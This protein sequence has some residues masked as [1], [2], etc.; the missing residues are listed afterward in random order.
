MRRPR[1]IAAWL[2]AAA[3]LTVFAAD[4]HPS[5]VETAQDAGLR[6]THDSGRVGE[7]WTLEITGAGVGLLDYDDDGR[8][9]VWLVQGGPLAD[10][11]ARALPSDRLFRNVGG[12]RF[13]DVT[14]EAGINA[15]GYGMG[16][17]TADVDND[18]DTDVFV[19]NYGANQLWLN[20]G[21]GTFEDVTASSGLTGDLWSISASFADVDGD[22]LLD[23][24]VA[25]YL[26]FAIER[27]QPCQLNSGQASYCAPGSYEAAPDRLY[28][29]LGSGRFVDVT[30][31]AGI[32]DMRRP[33]MGVVTADFNGDGRPDF[34]VANDADENALW[35]NQGGGR[36]VDGAPLAGV[37]VNGHGIP[38]ASMGLVA[39]D[40]DGDGASDIFVTHDVKESNT[41]YLH[42]TGSVQAPALGED[43]RS[44]AAT[45]WFED[46][47]AAA[48][49]AAGS[50]ATTGF[51]VGAFDADHDGD[52]DM[53]VVNGAVQ[54]VERQRRQGIVPPLRQRNQLWLNDGG[55]RFRLAGGGPAFALEATS[56]GAAFGDLDNDG[57]VDIVVANNHGAAH[58]YRNDT[59]TGAWLGIDLGA[60]A[61]AVGAVVALVGKP[62]HR[63]WNTDGSYAS[64]SDPRI[65]FGL[66]DDQ[67]PQHVLVRWR[68]GLEQRI[69]PLAPNRYHRL[70][71]AMP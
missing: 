71:R 54:M 19:A 38:E 28:R 6:F 15:A 70:R 4:R 39:D 62:G 36:F 18:G 17:A 58:L 8:L 26:D 11:D 41:L 49:L 40:L 52:L 66:G 56:R 45:G 2:A 1:R 27:H 44:A 37:A 65:V 35:L 67:R 16:I 34:Y 50:M 68:D 3:C 31:A 61:H 69:G 51:G 30:D 57:D 29:N 7:L 25:N 63:R 5:F 13:E 46:R 43:S 21:N 22:G 53:V 59:P 23:L 10:R 48:G 32:G 60:S 24:Y 55:G 64:A 9:D 12:V 20:L 42:V 33:A 47:T 14:A